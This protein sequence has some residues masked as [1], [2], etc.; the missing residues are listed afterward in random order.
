MYIL[1]YGYLPLAFTFKKTTRH[2]DVIANTL[3][4]METLPV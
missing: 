2:Q 1:E 3:R 4:K